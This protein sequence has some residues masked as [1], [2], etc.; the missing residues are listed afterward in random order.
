MNGHR[1]TTDPAYVPDEGALLRFTNL[2]LRSRRTIVLA[3]LAG[4][5]VGGISGLTGRRLYESRAMFLPQSSEESLS[6][7]ALAASQFGV[8]VPIPTGGGWGAGVYARLLG[9]PALRASVV[10]ESVTVLEEGGRRTTLTSLLKVSE[11]DPARVEALTIDALR[12]V[13]TITENKTLGAVEVSVRTRW[14]SVSQAIAERLVASVHR[15]NVEKLQAKATAE[16]KF[17]ESRA[18]LEQE[19]LRGAE[20]RLQAFLQQNRAVNN[21]PELTFRRD[22]LQ[23]EVTLHEQ[24]Y[25]SLVKALDEARIREVRDTPVITIVEEPRM[26]VL[27]MSRRTVL[28]TAL[29]IFGGVL[30]GVLLALVRHAG[31]RARESTDE[32]TREFVRLLEESLP[33]PLRRL[34]G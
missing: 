10:A 18:A 26:P 4:G 17:I 13:V 19:T 32:A 25:T 7:L 5:L 16:R 33:R 27:G 29:G 20:E 3:G 23:R 12:G 24:L 2:L 1:G 30:L 34:L 11:D 21:S 22:R 6:G 8:D 31:A 15:F 9:T 14:P 28:K